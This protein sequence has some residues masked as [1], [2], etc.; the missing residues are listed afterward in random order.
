MI[1]QERLKELY[2]HCPKS[3][4][5]IRKKTRASAKKGSSA[6][7]VNYYGYIE[8]SVDMKRY[9][10]HRLAWLYHYGEFPEKGFVVHHINSDGGDNRIENLQVLTKK[11][12]LRKPWY[13]EGNQRPYRPKHYLC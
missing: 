5:F 3:G 1:T 12:N 2:F 7:W 11:E 10:A 8:M 13:I 6:G 4:E 9:Y